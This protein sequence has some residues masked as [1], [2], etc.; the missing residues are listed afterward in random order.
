[1]ESGKLSYRLIAVDRVNIYLYGFGP[2][3][4]FRV[5]VACVKQFVRLIDIHILTKQSKTNRQQ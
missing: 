4:R 5:S 1:M 2:D 3:S